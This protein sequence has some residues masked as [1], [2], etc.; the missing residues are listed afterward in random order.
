MTKG[1]LHYNLILPLQRQPHLKD[2]PVAEAGERHN[3]IAP[4]EQNVSLFRKF[5]ITQYN[6]K[7]GLQK[8]QQSHLR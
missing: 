1:R 2:R 4:E 5:H 7:R 3:H 8:E 6:K